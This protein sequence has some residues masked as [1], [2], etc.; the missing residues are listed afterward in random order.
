MEKKNVDLFIQHKDRLHVN[1]Q[2]KS[3]GDKSIF[4]AYGLIGVSYKKCTD[5]SG[6]IEDRVEKA[7]RPLGERTLIQIKSA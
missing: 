7:V 6:Q 2:F 4:M 5:F 1:G 3:R